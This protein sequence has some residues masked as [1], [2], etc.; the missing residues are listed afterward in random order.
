MRFDIE[1]QL[2]VAQAFTVQAVSTNSYDKG[3]AAADPSIGE[4]MAIAVFPT[5]NAS[6]GASWALEV[7][8]S[9]AAALTSPDVLATVTVADAALVKGKCIELPIPQG[10]IT[11]RY[12]GLRA[13][14]TGGSSPTFTADAY[15]MPQC[16]IPVYKTF[17]KVVG[18]EM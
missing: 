15:Y 17:P 5:V 11:K 8:Q 1:N 18:S 13:T 14:P 6:G 9:A 12:L 16:D 2:S 4:R 7:I 3:T 10:S